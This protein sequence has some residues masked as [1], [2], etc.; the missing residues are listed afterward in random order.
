[1]R[2]HHNNAVGFA[3]AGL[4]GEQRKIHSVGTRGKRC[5]R[6][7]GKG[8]CGS[9][10]DRVQ[11]CQQKASYRASERGLLAM[12]KAEALKAPCDVWLNG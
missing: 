1:M 7:S 10:G 4:G 11:S 9:L 6:G 12:Q 5:P 8:C 2:T 3:G